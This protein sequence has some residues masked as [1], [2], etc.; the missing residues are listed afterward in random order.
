MTSTKKWLTAAAMVLGTA[1]AGCEGA[2]AKPE[3]PVVLAPTATA[4][5]PA[6]AATLDAKKFAIDAA[7]SKVDFVMDAP[8]EKIV[9]HVPG[10]STGTLQIDFMDVTKTTGLI[11]VDISGLTLFQAKPDK[12][13]KLG[14]E[15]KSDAQN[16]H[17]RTWL[18]IS[19]DAPEAA[20]KENSVVQFSIKS[21]E[22]KGEKNLTKLTGAERKVML[23]ATGDFLL[24]GHKSEKVAELEATFTFEGDKPVSVTIKSVK[25]F[26]VDL[27]E[28][29]VK[30]RDAFGKL[31]L[32][33]LAKLSTKV[34][35]DAMV[36]LD[37]TAKVAP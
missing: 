20:R 36:S 24:H 17:A 4:L 9:G 8:E 16:E 33:T 32:K 35:K 10:A 34:A 3:K 19:T 13:G 5:V 7:S 21:I 23:A 1:G 12:D 37:V 25:P 29:D 15:K 18:E 2:E 26:A 27:A 6:K 11:Q 31:A 22:A 28:H 14:P 30:P